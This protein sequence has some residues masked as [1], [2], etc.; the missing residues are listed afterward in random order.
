M[1]KG[2]ALTQNTCFLCKRELAKEEAE[3]AFCEGCKVYIC[4][5]CDVG[6]PMGK[7]QPEAHKEDT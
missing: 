4:D 7:H 1:A 3:E 5:R 6:F 2:P